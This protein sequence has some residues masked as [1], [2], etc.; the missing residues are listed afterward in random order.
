MPTSTSEPRREGNDYLGLTNGL[1]R[2]E[3]VPAVGGAI[4]GLW[5]QGL[6]VFRS[7]PA[8]ELQSP[9]KGG[10]FALLPYSNRIGNGEMHWR[11]KQYQL[12]TTQGDEP[13]SI[14]GVGW[15]RTWSVGDHDAVHVQL[16]YNHEADESWPF[17]FTA[18]Q[19]IS[20]DGNDLLL[21]LTYRNTGN[22]PSPVGLGWHPYFV[23]LP[24][25][26]LTFQ[27]NWRWET[28]ADKVPTHRTECTGYSGS[29]EELTV[30]NCYDGWTGIAELSDEKMRIR[31]AS[32]TNYLVVFTHPGVDFVAI[33]PVSHISNAQQLAAVAGLNPDAF[34]VHEL[35]ANQ[36]VNFNV[37]IQISAMD[38]QF[39]DL[40]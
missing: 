4:S 31:V 3:I 11:G 20:I 35:E 26:R 27:T 30:D 9:R 32:H 21:Q 29:C 25:A 1:L 7:V 28:A 37:K 10:C 13:H 23:K 8:A 24:G 12:R 36:I 19:T 40:A 5:Y 14:H 18:T 15:Q 33:E 38:G 34:G 16:I 39:G 17:P 6:P 22:E 2:C